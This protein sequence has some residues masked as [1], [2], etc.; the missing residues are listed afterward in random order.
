MELSL[1]PTH[2]HHQ[3]LELSVIG[4]VHFEELAVLVSVFGLLLVNVDGGCALGLACEGPNAAFFMVAHG[5]DLLLRGLHYYTLL[6]LSEDPLQPITPCL[7]TEWIN[8]A[9]KKIN[10][11]EYY[12]LDILTLKAASSISLLKA[13]K[14]DSG[15]SPPAPKNDCCVKSIYQNLELTGGVDGLEKL[16]QDKL[17]VFI[18]VDEVS[19]CARVYPEY[20]SLFDIE[21]LP[22]VFIGIPV[23]RHDEGLRIR[24]EKRDPIIFNP[25]EQIR[26]LREPLEDP[27]LAVLCLHPCHKV[28]VLENVRTI[29]TFLFPFATCHDVLFIPLLFPFTSCRSGDW[30]CLS[31]DWVHSRKRSMGL[32][33]RGSWAA[34]PK[35]AWARIRPRRANPNLTPELMIDDIFSFFFC[36]V[37]VF[38][39]VDGK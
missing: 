1:H 27:N 2:K 36:V 14:K 6:L 11:A 19:C 33:P 37:E 31:H 30:R 20:I 8:R 21:A 32:L 10:P 23:V 39:V 26:P 18:T 24:L 22:P 16:S 4:G 15:F 38:C 5:P 3:V 9:K 7:N 13:L 25:S 12:R 28:P 35:A 17:L 29:T 34:R